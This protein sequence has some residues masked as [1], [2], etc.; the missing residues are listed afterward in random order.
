ML[1]IMNDHHDHGDRQDHDE[2]RD[3]GGRF[4]K[5]GIPGPGRPRGA[6][7]KLSEAFLQDLHT[8]WEARGL[9]AL[10]QCATKRPAEFCRIIAGLLPHDVRI[11][12]AIDAAGFAERYKSAV[13]LL[14]NPEPPRPRRSLRVIEHDS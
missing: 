1:P 2:H 5:G 14:G 3:R 7:S 10:E 8:V 13:E 4:V 9:K 11:D 6:R 12:V